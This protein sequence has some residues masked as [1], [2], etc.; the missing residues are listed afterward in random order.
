MTK[1]EVFS[2][3]GINEDW[4]GPSPE[5]RMRRRSKRLSLYARTEPDAQ[6][7]RLLEGEIFSAFKR[8]IRPPD[9]D[10]M[11]YLRVTTY[12]VV[13]IWAINPRCKGE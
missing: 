1:R 5:R 2:R 10:E 6:A 12:P 3:Y 13:P 7:P 9:P 11:P 8:A 4:A